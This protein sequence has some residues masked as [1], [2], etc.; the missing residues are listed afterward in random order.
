MKGK[1]LWQTLRLYT[2]RSASGRANY[3]KGIFRHVG[4]R[5]SFM[6]RRV[7]LYPELI[8]IGNNVHM[9]S[10]VHL[11][12]HDIIHVAVNRM[13]EKERGGVK[14]QEHI[15]CIRIGDNVFIGSGT[16]ILGDVNIGSNVVIGASS[17]VIK[18]IPD[19]SVVGGVPARVICSFD[20]LVAKRAKGEYPEELKPNKEHMPAELADYLWQKFDEKRK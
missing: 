11:T 10:N 2:I 7:P 13:D 8:S 15:G 1:R 5:C 4:D 14:L 19:N 6:N 12:T 16:R 3:M 17:L 18:D 20:D 9:G